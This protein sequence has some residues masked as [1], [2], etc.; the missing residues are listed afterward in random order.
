MRINLNEIVRFK[1]TLTGAVIYRNYMESSNTPGPKEN[2]IPE[3][4]Q[5][6]VLMKIFGPHVYLRS[7]NIFED[8]EIELGREEK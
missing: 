6:W 3:S 2:K 1:L 5:L 7:P 4:M 8:S